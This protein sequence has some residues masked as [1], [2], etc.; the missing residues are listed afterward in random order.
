MGYTQQNRDWTALEKPQI[1]TLASNFEKTTMTSYESKFISKL[2]SPRLTL[3]YKT[4]L[5]PLLRHILAL[6][7]NLV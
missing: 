2:V 6:E 3:K 1:D 4:I 5:V 7:V